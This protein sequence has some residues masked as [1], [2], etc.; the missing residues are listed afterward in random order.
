MKS[1]SVRRYDDAMIEQDGIHRATRHWPLAASDWPR[2]APALAPDVLLR[3]GVRKAEPTLGTTLLVVAIVL[4]I[5]A[6]PGWAFS[7]DWGYGPSGSI[8]LTLVI[9]LALWR[10][11]QRRQRQIQHVVVATARRGDHRQCGRVHAV[12]RR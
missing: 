7:R 10:G 8:A 9:L 2:A 4:L 3:L 6:I 1:N 5:G 12:S 11:G